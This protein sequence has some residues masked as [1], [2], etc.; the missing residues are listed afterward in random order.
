MTPVMAFVGTRTRKDG[1]PYYS[2]TYR[3]GGRGRARSH[4]G[5][6]YWL[7]QGWS[8]RALLMPVRRSAIESSDSANFSVSGPPLR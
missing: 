4:R 1:S 3:I 7:L 2:V 8:R 6:L 5:L